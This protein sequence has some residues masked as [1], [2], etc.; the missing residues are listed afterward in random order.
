MPLGGMGVGLGVGV[1]EGVGVGLGVGVGVGVGVGEVETVMLSDEA[2]AKPVESQARITMECLPAARET[3]AVREF[4]VL[5]AFCTESMYM[6][7][8]VTVCSLSSAAA[9]KVTGEL[10]VAPLSGAQIFTVLSI[11]AVQ[12]CA[13]ARP[14][15]RP[16]RK[17]SRVAAENTRGEFILGPLYCYELFAKRR[18][19]KQR[20][21]RVKLSC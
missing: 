17:N 21:Q 9:L 10:T 18:R 12:V 5:L 16:Q 2:K 15:T 19:E 20:I 7:I 6:I 8:A 1:G 14:E 13:E 11:V 4:V 3:I